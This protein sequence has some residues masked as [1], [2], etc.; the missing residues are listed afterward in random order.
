MPWYGDPWEQ[1]LEALEG[2]PPLGVPAYTHEEDR[3]KRRNDGLFT[4][5]GMTGRDFGYD[6]AAWRDYLNN[7]PDSPKQRRTR[8]EV[9]QDEMSDLIDGYSI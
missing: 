7:D 2:L 4:L 6:A 3:E 1:L 5:R 8:G 9:E